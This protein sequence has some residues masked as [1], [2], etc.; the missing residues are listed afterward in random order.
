MKYSDFLSQ[1][2]KDDEFRH[3]YEKLQP[4]YEVIKALIEAR[5]SIN[6]TQHELSVKSGVAQSDISRIESGNGNPTLK[7]LERLAD[8]MDMHLKLE[9]LPNK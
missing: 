6:M 1:K 3:E 4:Q 8:G 9:F 2:M 7:M 5:K